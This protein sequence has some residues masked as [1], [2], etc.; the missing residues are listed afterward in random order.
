MLVGGLRFAS[1]PHGIAAQQQKCCVHRFICRRIFR[2]FAGE[3]ILRVHA[4]GTFEHGFSNR[5]ETIVQLSAFAVRYP[6]GQNDFITKVSS[7]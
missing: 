3:N 6:I 2:S 4:I 1:S 5:G 7:P